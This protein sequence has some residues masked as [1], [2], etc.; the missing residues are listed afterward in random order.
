MYPCTLPPSLRSSA[1]LANG[2]YAIWVCRD[3]RGGRARA[4]A[5][6]PSVESPMRPV[7]PCGACRNRRVH[8]GE[9]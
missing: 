4:V 2:R 9:G 5:V 3:G 1:A 7:T 8:G 6:R